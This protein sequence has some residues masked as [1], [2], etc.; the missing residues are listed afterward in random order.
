MAQNKTQDKVQ[1]KVQSKVGI[2]TFADIAKDNNFV[3]EILKDVTGINLTEQE[4]T[5]LKI[6]LRYETKDTL[7]DSINNIYRIIGANFTKPNRFII[8]PFIDSKGQE[9]VNIQ[10]L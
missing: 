5:K 4:V 2:N 7:F 6:F 8:I 9:H 1:N 3:K 10:K